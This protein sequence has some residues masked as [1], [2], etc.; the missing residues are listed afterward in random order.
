M[1][2]AKVQNGNITVADYREL[3]PNTS[4][5]ITGPNDEFFTENECLKVVAF[6]NHNK[7]TEMLVNC[8]PY[9]ENGIVYTVNIQAKADIFTYSEQQQNSSESTN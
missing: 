1:N 9:V 2:I 3:F 6:K 4:F 5:P 7:D 8:D